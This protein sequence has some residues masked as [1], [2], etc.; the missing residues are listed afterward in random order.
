MLRFHPRPAVSTGTFVGMGRRAS[1]RLARETTDRRPLDPGPLDG[2]PLDGWSDDLHLALL[3]C[4][5]LHLAGARG[6]HGMVRR[7]D[8]VPP[9]PGACV[10][11]RTPV[12]VQELISTR[13][14]KCP[15][16]PR[17]RR[18]AGR[19]P[20]PPQCSRALHGRTRPFRSAHGPR[21][22][23]RTTRITPRPTR[24]RLANFRPR[25]PAKSRKA[26]DSVPHAS[27]PSD[28]VQL[29]TAVGRIAGCSW[30]DSSAR[31]VSHDGWLPDAR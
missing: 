30:T 21:W 4:H 22:S 2:G 14:R 6:R 26:V 31:S 24:L 12:S 8:R 17:R 25:S 13:M 16:P 28:R 15:P 9:P 20:R 11:R 1:H 19:P 27:S 5:E 10:R 18:G 3:M 7:P 23:G 29:R